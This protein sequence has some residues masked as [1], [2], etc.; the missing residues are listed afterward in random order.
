MKAVGLITEYNPMHKG[1]VK[2]LEM[3]KELSGADV[4]VSVMSGD[5]VQRGEP[6][7]MDKYLRAASA[8]N[9]GV[10]LVVELPVR[11]ATAS[12]EGF[13]TGAVDI[14]HYLGVDSICFGSESGNIKALTK[15]ASVLASEPDGFSDLIR[16][17]LKTGM[18]YPAAR[19]AAITSLGIF[20]GKKVHNL[21]SSPNNILGIEY[22][23]SVIRNAYDIKCF[24]YERTGL[25]Y[26]EA[27]NETNDGAAFASSFAVRN[28]IFEQLDALMATIENNAELD[29]DSLNEIIRNDLFKKV[30]ESIPD[31][32][33]D[34]M[35]ESFGR[36]MPVGI[37][38]FKEM[39][40]YKINRLMYE[41]NFK[42]KELIERLC[43]YEGI[44]YNLA[45]RIANNYLPK[46]T[47]TESIMNIK[48]KS[49]TYTAVSRALIHILLGIK[50][51]RDNDA[52]DNLDD[53]SNGEVFV[54]DSKP[55]TVPYIRILGM[56]KKGREY[57][58]SIKKD[59][60]VPIITKV[61]GNE[62]ILAE[63]IFASNLYN[64]VIAEQFG[65]DVPDEFKRGIY[66]YESGF[67]GESF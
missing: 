53:A 66:I 4:A 32:T 22:I 23:K 54:F 26:D 67:T 11:Y 47:I 61:A 62:E 25:A 21:L 35:S 5:F 55:D 57:L 29:D 64:L 60:L 33:E 51:K 13:A 6:A 10:D 16:E 43:E 1:H 7:V 15:I 48:D 31:E 8:V 37:D 24:T 39:L 50:K 59:C 56:N 34:I 20:D 9:S 14:L 49:L 27:F 19:E 41:T 17:N 3:S 52:I 46:A 36:A 44:G 65:I 45:G 28:E 18:S 40:A 2:H 58:N 42:K 63:D 30:F 38:D 12:A